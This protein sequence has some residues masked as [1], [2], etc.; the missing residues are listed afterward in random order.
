MPTVP[1]YGDANV[2]SN[3]LPGAQIAAP[4]TTDYANKQTQDLGAA[5][6]SAGQTVGSIATDI[7]DQANLVRSIDATAAAKEKLYDTMYAPQTGLLAQKGWNALNRD[8]GTD[9]A[10][11]YG[12]N[13]KKVTDDISAN[14][15]N[16]AQR[17]MFAQQA[18]QM[19]TQLHATAE[20]HIGQEYQTYHAG[21]MDAAVKSEQNAIGLQ[22]S[23]NPGQLNPLTGRPLI[24]ES[25]DK[26][27]AATGEKARLAGLPQAAADNVSLDAVSSAHKLAIDGLLEQGKYNQA[28]AYQ[29]QYKNQ[30]NAPDSLDI[31]GKIDSVAG[32]QNGFGVVSKVMSS[33]KPVL[34][35]NSANLMANITTGTESGNRQLNAD[36]TPVT[37]YKTMPDG[38]KVGVAFGKWQV[39]DGTGKQWAKE[40]GVPWDPQRLR[41]DEAYNSAIGQYGL[42]KLIQQN[43]GDPAKAWAAYNAG[44][45]AVNNAVKLAAK[46]AASGDTANANWV[47]HLPTETQNYVT[48]NMAL[49]QSGGG[50]AAMPTLE[51]VLTQVHS[52][53]PPNTNPRVLQQIDNETGRQFSVMQQA[54]TQTEAQGTNDALTALIANGG[55]MSALPISITSKIPADHYDNVLNFASTVQRGEPVHTNLTLY[56]NLM[57]DDTY[58]HKL[59]A[60]QLNNVQTQLSP[61]DFKTV[62]ARWRDLNDPTSTTTKDPGNLNFSAI[63]NTLT[64]RLE[65]MGIKAKPKADDADGNARMGTIRQAVNDWVTR[66]QQAAGKKFNDVETARTIDDAF[67]QNIT[68]RSTL[69]GMGSS[70]NT[71]PVLG[72]HKPADLPDAARNAIIADFKA[73]GITPSDNDVVRTFIGARLASI[74]KTKGK[75]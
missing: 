73:R 23:S 55:N 58:L 26:I 33:V 8:S 1:S 54:K 32:L 68:L 52:Q 41:T 30:L 69:F 10:T 48:K 6:Q 34:Q 72:L 39:T 70:A 56:Q 4:T 71:M 47:T 28:A 7:Q 53:L 20:Q 40:M 37:G 63:N 27:R 19:Q 29:N 38:S 62:T 3:T 49:L 14:L 65:S 61:A 66:A 25:V 43:A 17:A 51:D 64:S 12:K 21:V 15:G 11:E 5:E 24:D 67:S 42:N 9:L 45:G 74:Q 31:A 22:G 36:G 60:T 16:D 59:S 2:S 13:F 75:P 57:G 50:R 44:Q 18:T 46:A 35:P